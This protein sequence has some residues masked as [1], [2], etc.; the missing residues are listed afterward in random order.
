MFCR[1]LYEG[2]DGARALYTPQPLRQRTTRR[3][4][5]EAMLERTM[6]DPGPLRVR[7]HDVTPLSASREVVPRVVNFRV[8][9]GTGTVATPVLPRAPPAAQTTTLRHDGDA[10]NPLLHLRE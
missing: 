6:G 4:Y 10:L 1:R 9:A 3:P 7:L 8:P 2:A 5:S